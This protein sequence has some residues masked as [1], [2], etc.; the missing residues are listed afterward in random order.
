MENNGGN[1][2][3]KKSTARRLLGIAGLLVAGYVVVTSLPD[4]VRYIKISTM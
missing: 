3:N 1:V 4:M 2:K